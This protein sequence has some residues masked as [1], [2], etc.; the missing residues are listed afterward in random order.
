VLREL[1]GV[2]AGILQQ[3]TKGLDTV[4]TVAK[5]SQCHTHPPE[6]HEGRARTLQT[7]Q[8]REK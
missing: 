3:V 7:C 5:G 8:S 2:T 4:G 6:G 1:R